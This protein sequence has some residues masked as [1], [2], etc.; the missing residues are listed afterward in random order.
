MDKNEDFRTF[1][2]R[3]RNQAAQ[4]EPPMT[5]TELIDAFMEIE[6]LDKQYKIAYAT[7]TD[8]AHLMSTRTRIEAALRPSS[9]NA[10]GSKSSKKKDSEVQHC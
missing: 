6:D 2:L 5:E 8:F 7:A 1:A 9:D 4:A 10:Q 3:W